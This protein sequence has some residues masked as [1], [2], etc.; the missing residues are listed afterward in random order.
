MALAVAVALFVH[1]MVPAYAVPTVAVAG[2]PVKSGAMSDAVV[3]IT[4][5]AELLPPVVVPPT[6]SF[7]APV[8][9]VYV[10]APM[11]VG[12]PL[13]GQEM[14]APGA[15]VAGGAGVHVPIVTPGG[16]PLIA[17]VAAVALSG[18]S[19]LL[20]HFRVPL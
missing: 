5:L 17:H 9:A 6:L 1:L 8:V 10:V 12:V 13:T 3:V 14:L 2:R 4:P 7:E 16:R 11:D 18:A 20:V 19:A 15:T